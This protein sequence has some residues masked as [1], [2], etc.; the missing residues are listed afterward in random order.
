MVMKALLYH[1]YSLFRLHLHIVVGV[2]VVVCIS[3]ILI[4]KQI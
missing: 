2:C 4:F 3:I 1:V